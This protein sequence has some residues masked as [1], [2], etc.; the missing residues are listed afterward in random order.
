MSR[1]ALLWYQSRDKNGSILLTI[2]ANGKGWYKLSEM[3]PNFET[4]AKGSVPAIDS[5]P[6]EVEAEAQGIYSRLRDLTGS[7]REH[8]I[9]IMQARLKVLQKNI[10][11]GYADAY[12]GFEIAKTRRVLELLGA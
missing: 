2:G 3:A 11:N 1:G 12:T 7:H 5:T 10:A 8:N 4:Y 6:L 9:G